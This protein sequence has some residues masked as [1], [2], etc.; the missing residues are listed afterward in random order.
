MASKDAATQA[1]RKSNA[2]IAGFAAL[3]SLLVACG[4]DSNDTASPTRALAPPLGVFSGTFPCDDCPGIPTTVWLR[5]DGS[6]F[7][8]QLY[9]AD[10]EQHAVTSLGLWSWALDSE[11]LEL[12]GRGPPRR[13]TRPD[14]NTLV[15]QTPSPLVHRI[16]REPTRG[17]FDGTIRL[18]G[19]IDFDRGGT[20]FTE[21]VT[22]L[23][24]PVS[25]GGDYSRFAQQYRHVGPGG[26]PVFVLLDA[27]FEW[28][29]DGAPKQL[30]VDRFS[31]I[32]AEGR[33]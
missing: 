13:F 18:E 19:M 26:S 12:R 16:D 24:V 33:C 4:S 1:Y 32:R 3:S 11:T 15:M 27:T 17:R 2:A 30:I 28:R 10:G 7:L 21:C 20:T 9:H 6:Y 25:R 23:Q 29:D 5:A 31:T 14:S 8:E 22:G